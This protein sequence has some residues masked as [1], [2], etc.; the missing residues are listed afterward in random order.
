MRR[1]INRPEERAEVEPPN[2]VPTIFDREMEILEESEVGVESV[3]TRCLIDSGSQITG[4]S[5][6]FFN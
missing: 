4:I 1:T 3:N 2:S 5:Q 6:E